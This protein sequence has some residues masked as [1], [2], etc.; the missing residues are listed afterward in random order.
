MASYCKMILIGNLGRDGELKYTPAGK[1]VT[2]VS[3]AIDD[4]WV[5]DEASGRPKTEWYRVK[6]WGKQAETLKPFLLKGKQVYVEGRLSIQRWD[7]K[8][9]ERRYTPEV[10]A[11]TVRLL[12][13]AGGQG[14]GSRPAHVPEHSAV[15]ADELGQEPEVT[16]DDIPF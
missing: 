14:G 13:S 2:T 6:I 12:G 10:S 8:E 5:K 16:D 1:P 3:I 9:G 7:S 15:A 11:D 4:P